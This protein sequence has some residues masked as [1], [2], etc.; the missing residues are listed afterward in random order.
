MASFSE[1]KV[2]AVEKVNYTLRKVAE[3]KNNEVTFF[4]F[5]ND[6]KMMKMGTSKISS[7]RCSNRDQPCQL[8]F[9]GAA[10][11]FFYDNNYIKWK[12][13][14]KDG[15][16]CRDCD[17][18]SKIWEVCIPIC[19]L[20]MNKPGASVVLSSFLNDAAMQYS[21]Y[22]QPFWRCSCVSSSNSVK[23]TGAIINVM[24]NE[25]LEMGWNI[26]AI[27][28]MSGVKSVKSSKAIDTKP[29]FDLNNTLTFL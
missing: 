15:R 14:D 13:I 1:L 27:S 19:S 8:V 25:K 21:S 9:E 16:E 2:N 22:K 29:A 28:C 6:G 24:G 11:S 12:S 18:F 23:R 17:A 10:L 3:L 7:Y 20:C 5:H 4:C 26:D